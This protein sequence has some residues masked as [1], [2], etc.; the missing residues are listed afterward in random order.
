MEE[1][2]TQSLPAHVDS[3]AGDIDLPDFGG[4][5][6]LLSEY[7]LKK[8]EIQ[9]RQQEYIAAHPELKDMLADYLQLVLHRKPSDVYTFT[10]D[11]FSI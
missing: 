11:Y 9:E 8:T 3:S 2:A 5:I 7:Q 10:K 6:E 1:T 4:N